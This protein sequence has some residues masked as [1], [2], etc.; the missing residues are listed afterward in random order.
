MSSDSALRPVR[1]SASAHSACPGD[2][3]APGKRVLACRAGTRVTVRSCVGWS[4]QQ[5]NTGFAGDPRKTL[6]PMP[7]MS[8]GALTMCVSSLIIKR[9]PAKT[10]ESFE[11]HY[12]RKCCFADS[13]S[14]RRRPE[15]AKPGARRGCRL[16]SNRS[17]LPCR[18][19]NRSRRF[20]VRNGPAGTLGIGLFLSA[21]VPS[22]HCRRCNQDRIK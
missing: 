10:T 14:R 18:R 21:V 20:R 3:R 5:T 1:V 2:V 11:R 17:A 15:E 9:F 22:R 12:S 4:T 8:L 19:A 13:R 6:I 16:R 7:A